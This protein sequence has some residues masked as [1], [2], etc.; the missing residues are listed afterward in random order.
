VDTAA[1]LV[2]S[3]VVRVVRAMALLLARVR[4]YVPADS[5]EDALEIR[6]ELVTV[7]AAMLTTRGTE[8]CQRSEVWRR[9]AGLR[10][11]AVYVR[12]S[13]TSWP[14]RDSMPGTSA[15]VC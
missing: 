3:G 10:P 9:R 6:K 15:S 8:C 1:A 12:R 14:R 13:P 4:W 7:S 11:M 2:R 5:I